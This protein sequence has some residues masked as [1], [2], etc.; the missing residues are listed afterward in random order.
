MKLFEGPGLII[1][2]A[3]VLIIFGPKK[4]PELGESIGKTIRSLREGVAGA[5]D[6]S[7]DPEASGARTDDASR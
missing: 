5:E 1:I 2:L 3:I 6:A 7:A 4:L